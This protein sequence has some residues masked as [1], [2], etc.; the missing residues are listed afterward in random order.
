MKPDQPSQLMGAAGTER[1]ELVMLV[2][3]ALS[4]VR[5]GVQLLL[6]VPSMLRFHLLLFLMDQRM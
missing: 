5:S 3:D 2:M 1:T 6:M 4:Q